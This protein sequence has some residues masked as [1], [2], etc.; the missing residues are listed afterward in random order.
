MESRTPEQARTD[1]RANFSRLLVR[2]LFEIDLTQAQL[3]E[4]VG[5]SPQKVQRWC[6][7]RNPE[8]PGLPDLRLF[9]RALAERC[10][11]WLAEGHHLTVV[12]E[13]QPAETARDLLGEIHRIAAS[14]AD[15]T[16]TFLAALANDGAVDAHERRELIAKLKRSIAVEQA[17][18]L[19]LEA[20]ERGGLRAVG[21]SS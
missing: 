16:T 5:T 12:D 20:E 2:W 11:A 6:D 7:H 18:L 4:H 19:R 15:V 10:F 14:D 13:L 17:T 1:A 3:A 9:P 8:V 21:S